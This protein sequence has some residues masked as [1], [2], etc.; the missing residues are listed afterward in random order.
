MQLLRRL[1]FT[2]LLMSLMTLVACGDGDGD[3][4]GGD[5]GGTDP[6]IVTLTMSKSD[7]DLSAANDII[8]MVTVLDNS[9]P[10]ANKTVTFTFAVEGSAT[11]DPIA[12]TATTDAEGNASITVKVN[13]VKGSVNVIATYE[14]TT[15]N[16]S[17][18]S[19]G[20][21]E[22]SGGSSG[23]AKISLEKSAGDL[24]A[25]ND[26]IISASIISN[27]TNEGVPGKLVTFTFNNPAIATFDPAVGTAVT[28]EL[29]IATVIVKV[30]DVAG[31]VEVTAVTSSNS[32]TATTSISFT[33]VGDGIKVVEGAPTA[34]TISL[35]A[36][37]QQL[38]SSGTEIVTLTAIA[39]DDNNHL[40]TGVDINFS[41]DSGTIGGVEN[42]EGEISSVT[43]INGRVQKGLIT[44]TNPE[45][46]VI[47]VNV[48]SGD[49]TDSLEIE[50]VGT[51]ITLAGTSSLALNDESSYIVKLVDSD[52]KG[53]ARTAVAVSADNA[54][55]IIIPSSVTTD[56][57]GQA[58]INVT[59]TSGG[60]NTI[61]ITALGASASQDISV[62]ADSFLFTGFVE[63]EK[64]GSTCG[65]VINPSTN[66][67]SDIL[68]SK[69]VEV[70]LTW[71]RSGLPVPDGTLVNFTSTRGSLA[72]DSATTVAGKVTATL[73]SSNAGKALL[74]FTGVDAVDGENIELNNQLEFEFIADTAH[75]IIAQAFPVSIGPNEKISTVSVVVRDP[76]G[77]LVKNKTVKF[78]LDDVSGGEIFP[79]TA[80]TDSNGSTSTV[81]TSSSTSAY[82]GVKIT[83]TVVDTPA[84]T[85]S[86]ALTVADR[87]VFI[88]LGTGN[89]ILEHD[90]NTYNKQYSVFVTDI[91]SNP[92]PDVTLT[93]SAIPNEY[94]KG[95]WIAYLDEDGEFVQW[96]TGNTTVTPT[97]MGYSAT[98]ANEDINGNGVLDDIATPIREEDTNTDGQLTPGNI[99]NA[100][101]VVTTDEYGI[102]M[103][104]IRYAEVYG[105][106]ANIELIVSTKVNGTESFAKALF[107]LDV[108]S[109][110]VTDEKVTPAAFLWPS[111]PFGQSDSC[112]NPD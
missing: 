57:A 63:C 111:G 10:V 86:I 22:S 13:D 42:A 55:G 70:T 98:C 26:I 69:K 19:A 102:A 105:Y 92:V 33:S 106:W 29:G 39:K 87:E 65:E 66:E 85:D 108:L 88:K 40:L 71:L 36:S 41:V 32:D 100:Q 72:T 51:R 45:N 54:D 107:N 3:L 6:D 81:Y 97:L 83:T 76:E 59:G 23:T 67:L 99:V 77:N 79:A 17:F 89:T 20:D 21:G 11:F 60:S 58:T 4:T 7:G 56:L 28:N 84:V 112:T 47:T 96:G 73:T 2:L 50:V 1:S 18:D 12:G 37:S 48:S 104:D 31:G 24:S 46:R 44:P 64:N 14:S 5:D 30:T 61:I 27:D 35:Y 80:V 9:I 110:D 52:G 101:G 16:I 93:V 68:L 62:Q 43:D 49:V 38:A 90:I 78:E 8:V 91:D 15:N 109:S 74:T 75:R 82:E 34:A 94:F 53:I 25:A 95:T 103:I